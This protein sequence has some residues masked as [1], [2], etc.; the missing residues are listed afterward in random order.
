[1]DAMHTVLQSAVFRNLDMIIFSRAVTPWYVELKQVSIVSDSVQM[2]QL[3]GPGM[4]VISEH[5]GRGSIEARGPVET[6]VVFE[7]V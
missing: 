3:D 4:E 2:L 7:H 1:M 5:I 6:S